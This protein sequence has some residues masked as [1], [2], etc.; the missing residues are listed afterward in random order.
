MTSGNAMYPNKQKAILETETK[1]EII[2]YTAFE[3][4]NLLVYDY[5][6]FI[7]VSR[8]QLCN[9]ESYRRHTAIS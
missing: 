1:S 7:D 3:K 2:I 6:K 8:L 4:S 5:T 9:G